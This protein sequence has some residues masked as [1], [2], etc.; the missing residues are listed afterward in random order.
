MR[1]AWLVLALVLVAAA[2]ACGDG[3]SVSYD[4]PDAAPPDAGSP[5]GCIPRP[6]VG[7]PPPESCPANVEYCVHSIRLW[8]AWCENDHV[9]LDEITPV[10]YCNCGTEQVVCQRSTAGD[11][12]VEL[13]C[14]SG[15]ASDAVRRLE[16]DDFDHF[17]PAS[18]CAVPDAGPPDAGG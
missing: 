17:D 16:G 5:P 10:E 11:P 2:A 12:V 9:L 6:H 18:L 8:D 4:P 14:T 1:S 7:P 15:C 13:A 3:P